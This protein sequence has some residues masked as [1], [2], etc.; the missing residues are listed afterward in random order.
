[1]VDDLV[2]DATDKPT[3]GVILCRSK[4]NQVVAEYALRDINKPIGLAEYRLTEAIPE[5]IRTNLPTIEELEEELRKG[6]GE[7]QT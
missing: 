4:G 1:V 2:K 5:H 3:I 6:T 7:N